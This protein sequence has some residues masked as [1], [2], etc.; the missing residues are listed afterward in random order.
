MNDDAVELRSRE[1][2][3]EGIHVTTIAELLATN[4]GED[5][6]LVEKLIPEQSITAIAG[7][8][9]SFKTWITLEIARSVA[10]GKPFLGNFATTQGPVLLVDKECHYKH[11]Q[12]RLK[13]LGMEKTL[14]I[15]Y[16]NPYEL[17]LFVD[18]DKHFELLLREIEHLGARVVIFD[19]LTR[20]HRGDENESK[21]I[22]KLMNRFKRITDIGVS[23]I[24]VHHHRKESYPS[25][26]SP[27]SL[28]GSSD[29]LAGI[30]CLL[31]LVKEKGRDDRIIVEQGK[32]RQGE[33][34]KPFAINA[35]F[36]KDGDI[37][38]SV[39]FSYGGEHDP[40]KT[41]SDEATGIILE[42]LEQKGD[43]TEGSVI[44]KVLEEENYSKGT[45]IR[46]LKQLEEEDKIGKRNGDNGRHIYWLK[47]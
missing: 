41:K 19:S 23:V 6:W 26:N 47:K 34:V 11:I 28:R 16:H 7:I 27:N 17:D 9:G 15:C 36:E 3:M 32:L 44:V 13:L 24:F 35:L 39:S 12:K 40:S 20:I 4:F 10:S 8:P 30:D 38:R 42:F 31:T 5:S 2:K 1:L 43:E 25:Q 18:D 22:A 29:I 21:S 46:A 37:T 45:T 14:P 33:A